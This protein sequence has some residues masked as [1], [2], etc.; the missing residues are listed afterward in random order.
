MA[1]KT[2]F[3]RTLPG[4]GAY[5]CGLGLIVAAT[6]LNVAHDHLSERDIALLPLFLAPLYEATGKF[7][8][9]LTL[10]TI[11][12]SVIMLGA[13]FQ[14]S[15]RVKKGSDE[16]TSRAPYFYT[17]SDEPVSHSSGTLVLQTQKYLAQANLSGTTGF[18]AA[19]TRKG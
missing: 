19:R 11:G 2:M 13:V 10:V 15:R 5:F 7:G 17:S 14:R 16:Y 1:T 4:L 6:I 9:T 8:V 12:L 18:P 3:T